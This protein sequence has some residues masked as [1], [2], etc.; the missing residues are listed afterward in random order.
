MPAG[1]S[2]RDRR[3]DLWEPL[4]LNPSENYRKT[5]GRWLLAFAR[6]KDGVSREQAQGQMSAIAARLAEAYPD[7]NKGWTVQ[8]ETLRDS[9]VRSVKASLLVLL[10]AVGLLLAVACAN[11]AN[12]L[13]ARYI[14]RRREIAVRASLGA[15][16]GRVIRQLLTE[17]LILTLAGGVLGI[18]LARWIVR[19]LLLLAPEGITT[20]AEVQVDARIYLFAVGL[21]LL[22]GLLFGLAPG[23]IAA[24]TDL[25][26][27]LR[28]ES[29]TTTGSSSHI[30]LWLVG[31]EVAMTVV[32]LIGALLLFR[33]LTGL[34][35][36]QPGLDPSNVLTLRVSL[37]AARYDR[38]AKRT[39][40]FG[41]AIQH[42]EALPGVRH[43][44][45]VSH[46]P[47][48][49]PGA[50]TWVRFEGRPEAKAGEELITLVRVVM[51]GY[52]KTLGIPLKRG[53]DFSAADN[54]AA[55]PL[56]FIVNEAFARKYLQGEDSLGKNISVLMDSQNPFGEIV[57]VAGDVKEVS[58]EK[59]AEPTA[60]YPH[61]RLGFSSMLLVVKT[62]GHPS[63]LAGAARQVVRDLDSVQPVSE[64]RT[65]DEILNEDFSRQRFSAFLLSVFSAAALIVAAIGIYGVVGHTVSER[66][67][68]IGL[69]VALG[70]E[71]RRIAGLVIGSGARVIAAGVLAGVCGSLAVTGLLRN[72]LYGV[73]PRDPLTFG[74]VTVLIT[75]MALASTYVPTRRALRLAPMDAL[76]TD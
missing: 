74:A 51:P 38:V 44:S 32:L 73:G 11:V 68:E 18:V 48:S 65:L 47:F 56:R 35:G 2:F 60:Y 14:S 20:V 63:G 30:R 53:R 71:P 76:R 50:G 9:L 6:M 21:S 64:V 41:Q 24:R 26:L 4:G 33:S 1:F 54:D 36:I 28:S 7:F 10:A 17:S 40:F 37:P 22:T 52:F 25:T 15:A 70:A 57:G 75:V 46:P 61:A 39:Q 23:L 31:A 34:Q 66:T 67:R 69:R 49:G 45:A 72:L 42:L 29:R 12:L 5:Q 55:G 13:L 58:V 16:R 62:D 3:I 43:A 19:G 59:D 8:V 27:S